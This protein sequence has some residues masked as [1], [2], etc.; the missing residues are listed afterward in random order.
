ML[1]FGSP[2]PLLHFI[3]ASLLLSSFK[4]LHCAVLCT[5]SFKIC[6]YVSFKHERSCFQLEYCGGNFE[7][8]P[9]DLTGKQ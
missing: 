6:R 7:G 5:L 4:Y 1:R 8:D 3:T 9:V 2:L